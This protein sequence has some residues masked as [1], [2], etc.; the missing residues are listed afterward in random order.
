M[1]TTGKSPGR[2]LQFCSL[3]YCGWTGCFSFD[4]AGGPPYPISLNP[5][6]PSPGRDTVHVKA[7]RDANS[8]EVPDQIGHRGCRSG[9]QT[10]HPSGSLFEGL[11]C[12]IP[13]C[14][15]PLVR[16]ISLSG[17]GAQQMLW[18][19]INLSQDLIARKAVSC[20]DFQV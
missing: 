3:V 13:V 1:R 6:C 18:R 15:L 19:E 7:W 8:M 20:C 2:G 9:R 10:K 12:L 4:G 17:F 14:S 16:W 11:L 5:L